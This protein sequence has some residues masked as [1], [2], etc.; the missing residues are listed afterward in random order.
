MDM[1]NSPINSNTITNMWFLV[2]FIIFTVGF[3]T[4][5]GYNFIWT[6]IGAVIGIGV[7]LFLKSK[8]SKK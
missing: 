3:G 7:G 2:P 1:N 4:V 5:T 6:T 8:F